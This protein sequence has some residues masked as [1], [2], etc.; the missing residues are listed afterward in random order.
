[1][2]LKKFALILSL[3]SVFGSTQAAFANPDIKDFLK[4]AA[5]S[6]TNNKTDNSQSNST[7]TALSGLQG[8]VEGLISN[9]NLTEADIVGSWKYSA[10]S[11]AFQSDNVLQKAGGSA[12]AGV[13]TKQLAPYYSKVG[14]NKLTATFNE[15]KTFSFQLKKINL[16]GTFEKDAESETGDF[17]FHFTTA[18]NYS[19]GQFK[20][21]VEKVGT[22]LT[23]TFDA[24]KLISLVNT[25]AKLSGKSS[26]QTVASLLNSYD[27]LN[28]GF[29]FTQSN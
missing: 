21:H 17:I 11:V 28:C 19:L 26:L 14:L 16:S 10:P 8:L 20:A 18:G 12:A 9:S 27:G 25:V 22:K 7:S 15:D 6:L 23:I 13:I 5:S 3:V 24:S 29:E 1:M 4:N 2:K